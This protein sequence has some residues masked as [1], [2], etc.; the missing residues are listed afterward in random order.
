MLGITVSDIP[1]GRHAKDSGDEH[2]DHDDADCHSR[3]LD[4][5]GMYPLAS[6][7]LLLI[8]NLNYYSIFFRA[9]LP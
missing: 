7:G 8:D 2:C 9:F 1:Y 6:F 3:Y 4:P 5:Y